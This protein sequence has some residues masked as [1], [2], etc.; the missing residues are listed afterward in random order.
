MTIERTSIRVPK[1]LPIF[2]VPV[3]DGGSPD[4]ILSSCDPIPQIAID[5]TLGRTHQVEIADDRWFGRLWHDGDRF[6]LQQKAHC[7]YIGTLSGADL[8]EVIHEARFGG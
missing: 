4:G 5:A 8:G 2:H 1:R 3:E 7:E 6:H